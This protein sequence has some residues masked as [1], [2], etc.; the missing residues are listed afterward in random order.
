MTRY[1]RLADRYQAATEPPDWSEPKPYHLCVYVLES[2]HPISYSTGLANAK[3]LS[4]ALG[5]ARFLA[6]EYGHRC[7]I[8]AQHEPSVRRNPPEPAP[9]T[10]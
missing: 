5:Y 3:S 10:S 2:V 7:W 9:P 8:A 6:H 1:G 4:G